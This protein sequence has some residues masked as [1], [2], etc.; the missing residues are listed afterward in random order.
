MFVRAPCRNAAAF[1]HRRKCSGWPDGFERSMIIFAPRKMRYAPPS[2]L[3]KPNAVAE[4]KSIAD[5]PRAAAQ[6]W[7]ILPTQIPSAEAIPT[8][9][10]WA[11]VCALKCRQCP[12]RALD[13]GEYRPLEKV[14]NHE[15]RTCVWVTALCLQS[16]K[17]KGRALAS[18]YRTY[19]LCT[20]GKA[21]RKQRTHVRG[22]HDRL[23]PVC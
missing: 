14:Q 15:C 10:P 4:L 8:S 16:Q 9:R 23:S 5:R 17:A 22:C 12:A 3:I 21:H 2:S 7:K 11:T 13:S 6:V 18:A 20:P 19:V 1:V